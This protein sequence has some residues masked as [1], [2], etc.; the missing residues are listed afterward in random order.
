MVRLLFQE[1]ATGGIEGNGLEQRR[2]GDR[3]RWKEI[4]VI[5][6][7]WV[8]AWLTFL[9]CVRA[10]VPF[11]TAESRVICTEASELTNDV[12]YSG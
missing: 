6:L 1:D 8:M 10:A 12:L 2:T 9:L 11:P 7:A 3:E 4:D 5:V